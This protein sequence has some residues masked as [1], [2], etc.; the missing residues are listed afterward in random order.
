MLRQL[1]D[2]VGRPRGERL[3]L[4]RGR[5]LHGCRRNLGF[6]ARHDQFSPPEVTAAVL[7]EKIEKI[8]ERVDA[9]K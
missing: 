1:L 8:F 6:V 3:D 4:R 5:F 2:R 7:K 9:S